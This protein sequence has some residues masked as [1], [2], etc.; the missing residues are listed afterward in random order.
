MIDFHN[1]IL[2]NVDDGSKSLEM[3][4]NMLRE[5]E[6][7]GIT[8]VIN[9]VHFQHPKVEGMD[10]SFERIIQEI[11]NLQ[12]SA[13]E[14]NINVKIHN[15]AEV[16]YLPNLVEISE[17]PLTT[18]G[19]GK[20]MLIEF[21]THILPQGFE[22]EFYRLQL[23]GITPIVAHPERYNAIQNDCTI[24]DSW[25]E[26]GYMIQLDAGSILGQFGKVCLQTANSLMKSSSIHLIGSDSHNDK[27]GRASCRERV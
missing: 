22:D 16:F 23:N 13:I 4:L 10:I 11:E 12:K 21:P 15:G 6:R 20:Y 8:D 18:I 27:I 25:I 2:P 14:N 7:Q 9:T 5:A 17:N 3:S 19:N 26:R 24:I 1:H